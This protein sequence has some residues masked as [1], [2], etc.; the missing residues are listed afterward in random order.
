[1]E[2]E[3]NN[4]SAL[5]WMWLVAALAIIAS[6]A[7]AWRRRALRTMIDANL[8]SK[9][10]PEFSIWRPALRFALILFALIAVVAAMIDPRWGTESE[11]I[12]RRG[13]DVMFVVDVSRSMLAEDATPNRLSRAKVFIDDALRQMAGDRV[14]LVDFAGVA[15]MRTPLTLNYGAFM[16]SVDDLRP[17]DAVRG[18][19]MLGDAIRVAAESFSSDAT[20]GRAIVILTDG[21]DMGSDPIAAAKEIFEKQ[22][23]R[24]VTV[25]I[26]DSRDG[27]RIPVENDGDRTWMVHDGQEVWSKMDANTLR[28]IA[29]S[30]GGLFVPA[31]TSQVDLGDILQ[32]SFSDLERGEFET[33]TIQRSIP[34]FQWPAGFA[35]ILLVLECLIPDRKSV[36][37]IARVAEANELLLQR[38][39]S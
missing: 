7:V 28:D 37:K 36:K 33:S 14:G 35:L 30:G 9:I 24:I 21:E 32:R 8:L 38:G 16:T 3:Y 13:A 19:S 18:G 26:G 34:R 11:E 15:A 23:I 5:N 29:Q 2:I 6:M 27:G 1:M 25:G 20:A 10:A 17:K 39:V 12:K 22:G 4:L 31:G